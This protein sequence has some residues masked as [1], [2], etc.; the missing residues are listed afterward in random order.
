MNYNHLTL[1]PSDHTCSVSVHEEKMHLRLLGGWRVHDLQQNPLWRQE[2]T[3][4][5]EEQV[6]TFQ[7][8]G[9]RLLFLKLEPLD[10][11]F[12]NKTKQ[13][14]EKANTLIHHQT[15]NGINIWAQ[16]DLEYAQKDG[17]ITE[18]KL[19]WAKSHLLDV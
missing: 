9:V 6:I 5:Q 3:A 15:T 14:S 19:E 17:G 2:R 4:L 1:K 18:E 11:L 7:W 12:K 8:D 10:S 13:N 16:A